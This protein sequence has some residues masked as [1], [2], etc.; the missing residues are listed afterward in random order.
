MRK[1]ATLLLLCMAITLFVPATVLAEE[2]IIPAD[3]EII[4][5]YR[6][7]FEQYFD[8]VET[9]GSREVSV[10]KKNAY[11]NNGDKYVVYS[12]ELVSAQCVIQETGTVG[13]GE[14]YMGYH[15]VHRS[16]GPP[17]LYTY[18]GLYDEG[19]NVFYYFPAHTFKVEGSDMY[20]LE[21]KLTSA[22]G[23][24]M[25][26]TVQETKIRPKKAATITVTHNGELIN[27][28]QP[29]IAENGRTLVPLRAI[30]EKLGAT[31]AWDGN[32]QTVT[33]T[34][35]DVVITLTLNNTTATK[36]GQPV[37]LDVPAKA[38]NGRTLVPVRFI[39]DCFGVTTGWDGESQRVILTD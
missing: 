29:P 36:N 9:L 39:A 16:Y 35:G 22:G 20:I 23:E 13:I 19:G 11:Y 10:N 14:R 4:T 24:G 25:K 8:I 27:F 15:C 6:G 37:I 12:E 18:A 26:Y 32:T 31:V 7:D 3:V 38:I 5:L 17:N 28:D 21:Y 30:F 34:K 33:A 1:I 2:K